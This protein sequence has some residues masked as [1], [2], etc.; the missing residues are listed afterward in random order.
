MTREALADVLDEISL[1]LELK[2]ENPFKVR[3]YR[4]GAETVRGFDG[5]IVGLAAANQ[6]TGIKG[7]GEALRDK[8]HILAST[9]WLPYHQHLRAEFGRLPFFPRDSSIIGTD[10]GAGTSDRRARTSLRVRD[11]RTPRPPSFWN[12]G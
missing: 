7:I 1:L 10:N 9:G 6:L 5:D 3:A 12:T 11:R 2:N 8:L 4:Q